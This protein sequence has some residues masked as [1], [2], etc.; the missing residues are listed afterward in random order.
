MPS[1]LHSAES[2][3]SVV[4]VWVVSPVAASQRRAP[5]LPAVRM[6]VPSG[7][8]VTHEIQSRFGYTV[9]ACELLPIELSAGATSASPLLMTG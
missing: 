6:R 8:H 3:Q 4:R 9:S 5:L 7:L 1:G 2:V